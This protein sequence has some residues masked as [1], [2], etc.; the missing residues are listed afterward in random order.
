MTTEEMAMDLAGF[1][2]EKTDFVV[3]A[4]QK[5]FKE[6]REAR[7]QVLYLK[8]VNAHDKAEKEKEIE[9]KNSTI[10]EMNLQL[11]E[12]DKCSAILNKIQVL[13]SVVEHN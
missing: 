6:R 4:Y 9:E 11:A 5:A 10:A 12:K 2:S 7:T 1:V 8:A 13:Y 3:N